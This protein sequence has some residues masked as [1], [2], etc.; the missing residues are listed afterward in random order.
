VKL[1]VTAG[2]YGGQPE[3]DFIGIG[4]GVGEVRRMLDYQAAGRK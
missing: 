1:I 3:I 2:L 4:T